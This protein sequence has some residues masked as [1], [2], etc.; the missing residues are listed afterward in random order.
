MLM[1]TKVVGNGL[2]GATGYYHILVI[3][4][5]PMN[6]FVIPNSFAL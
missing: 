5:Q 3:P 4:H 6:E 2:I 1:L